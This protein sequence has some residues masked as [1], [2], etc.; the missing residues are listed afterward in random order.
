MASKL[1]EQ[2]KLAELTKRKF[3]Q[4]PAA[5]EDQTLYFM[6]LDR[7]SDGKEDGYRDIHGNPV[8]GKTPLY[9][10]EDNGNGV[11]TEADTR[12]WR[13]TG[14]KW[15]GGT[16]K[17]LTS[18]LGY[19]K[20]LGITAVWVS[21]VFKQVSFK[22]TY[23]GYGVQNFLE[24]DP[25]F[26]T[27]DDLKQMVRVAH[28]NGIYVILDIILNHS[29]DVFRYR[30]KFCCCR[31]GENSFP[32]WNGTQF[33]V[34]GFN[35]AYGEPVIEFKPVTSDKEAGVWPN[36][37]IWPKEFQQPE[38]FSRKGAIK[39]WEHYPEYLEGDFFELKDLMLGTGDVDHYQD[40]PALRALIDVY[41]YWIA[42][43]DLDG[44]RIDTVKH[45]DPG[46]V[47][48][49]AGAIHEFAQSLGK[50]KFYLIG[51]VVGER[52]HAFHILEITG[53]DAA[54]GIADIPDKLEQMVKGYQNPIEY[55]NNFRNSLLVDK[56][57]HTWFNNKVVTMF[58]DHDNI[59]QGDYKSRF[60]ADEEGARQV[61]N[62]LALNVTTL[63]IPCIYYGTEQGFDGHGS[64]DRYIREAMFGGG[65][66]AF[67]SK[68]RHFFNEDTF[69]YRELAEILQIRKEKIPLRR[70]RQYLRP[71]SG[72]GVNF[73]LPEM[74]GGRI[75][76][77]IPWSRVFSNK[78]ILVLINTDYQNSKTAWVTVDNS[79]HR[80][81]DRMRCIYSSQ[82]KSR[83]GQEVTVEERNEKSVKITAPACEFA[84][85][86]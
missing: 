53:I 9:Q 44:F 31:K 2:I 13:E 34:Q 76:S 69:V 82:D 18:K 84:I 52:R 85:Y 75:H 43:A 78:E 73:G 4:S 55:F 56:E 63:G 59:R 15:V 67:C 64:D 7:F 19:L 26:G 1:L 22:E 5:W 48:Y 83:I 60:C 25:H 47:R 65:F 54:L 20:R 70:G 30:P 8:S 81:G 57:S 79:L 12:L 14:Q 10:N 50:E 45:M 68:E 72:D 6:M 36:G 38:I 39:N 27:K 16:L 77:I 41:K 33:E 11:K 28:E 21:P 58:N 86:E 61:L 49:F 42:E 35:N 40:Y 51:E 32:C 74:V 80:A 23:H 66:G 24:V 17:G 3:H 62:A 37:A 46:A 71:I 29:G